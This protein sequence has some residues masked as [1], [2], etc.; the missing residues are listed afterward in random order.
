[1][2]FSR[3]IL[4]AV[5]LWQDPIRINGFISFFTKCNQGKKKLLL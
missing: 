5:I 4:T 1:M 3:L 2:G